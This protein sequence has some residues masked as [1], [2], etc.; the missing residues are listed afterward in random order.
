[1]R[2]D[3]KLT[4]GRKVAYA[5]ELEGYDSGSVGNATEDPRAATVGIKNS[6][7]PPVLSPSQ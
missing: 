3:H 5:H 4:T 7:F 6:G 2:S 1:M